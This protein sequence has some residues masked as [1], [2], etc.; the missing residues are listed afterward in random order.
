VKTGLAPGERELASLQFETVPSDLSESVASRWRGYVDRWDPEFGVYGWALAF[1][2]PLDPLRIELI[3]GGT[4]IYSIETSEARTDVDEVLGVRT[5]SGFR[6]GPEIYERLARLK[7]QRRHLRVNV[8]IANSRFVLMQPDRPPTV[9]ELVA[10][11]RSALLERLQ[12]REPIVTR[13]ERL[14]TRLALLRTQAEAFRELPLRPT[15]DNEVG[16][17]EAVYLASGGGLLWMTGWV[18]KDTPTEM[19]AMIVDRQK[20]PAGA[21]LLKYERQD[22]SSR[23]V[24]FVGVLETAWTPPALVRELFI[25]FG[26]GARR[27]LR[28]GSQMRLIQLEELLSLFLQAQSVTMDGHASALGSVL[29]SSSSWVPGSAAAAGMAAAASI[30]RLLM[31][32]GFGCIAEGWAVSPTRRV[33]TFQM[34]IGDCVLVADESSTYF[35]ARPD[36]SSVFGGGAGL[37]ARAGFVT[38]LRGAI[39]VSASGAPLLRVIHED[40]TAFVQRLEPKLLHPLDCISDSREILQLFPSFRH[41]RFYPALLTALR[42]QLRERIRPPSEFFA[43]PASRVIVM[44]LPA[45]KGNQRLCFDQIA[46]LDSMTDAAIGVCL[47]ADR[48]EGLTESKLLFEEISSTVSRALSLFFVEDSNDGFNALPFLLSQL[49]A[50]RF[51]YVDRGV[52]LTTRG[53]IQAIK[54]LMGHGQGIS[55]F[56]IVDDSGEPDR[57][58]GAVSAACFGWT[59]AALYGWVRSAPRFLRGVYGTNGLPEPHTGG[60][61]VSAAAMRI[62]QARLSRFA[63]L[64]DED[65]FAWRPQTRPHMYA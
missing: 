16:Q 18:T 33:S 38:V 63:D 36:L 14:T 56:E 15:A 40:G 27:Q 28:A 37:V 49:Q 54:A 26:E 22:L 65:L 53:W 2:S 9:G 39:T 23:Y 29:T 30:D 10:I 25:Y 43:A 55:F 34:K 51:V 8:R 1:D 6:F 17:I 35:R 61:V 47:V 4:P 7:P 64:I 48:G 11:W 5:L 60:Q 58:N 19:P 21:S 50:D 44:R 41:E 57:V 24:G 59:S 13:E 42:H 46:R 45:Q 12:E 52:L 20:Y 62:E 3:V 31:V 32:P